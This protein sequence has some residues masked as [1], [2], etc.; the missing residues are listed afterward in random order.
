MTKG[1]REEMTFGSFFKTWDPKE[2][3]AKAKSLARPP[4]HNKEQPEYST[5]VSSS[6]ILINCQKH[7]GC[8]LFMIDEEHLSFIL[9][10]Q[11]SVLCVF[12]ARENVLSRVSGPG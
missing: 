6:Y 11:V 4:N 9:L 2:V 12:I 3:T 10:H 1:S 8:I 5:S 7:E